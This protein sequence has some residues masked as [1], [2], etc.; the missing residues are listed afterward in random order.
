MSEALKTA[1]ASAPVNKI[2]L[3][4]FEFHHQGFTDDQ[5]IVR[6]WRFVSTLTSTEAIEATLEATAPVDAGKVV[7]F[8]P[9]PISA[10]HPERNDQGYTDFPISLGD[11][12]MALEEELDKALLHP[13]ELKVY[14]R[15]YLQNLD[16]GEITGPENVPFEWTLEGISNKDGQMNATATLVDVVNRPFPYLLYTP[17]FAPG[18]VR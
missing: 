2:V 9:A 15:L 6:P 10:K 7:R 11:V 12:T 5:G 1:Y 3:D 17:D 18:L 8:E 4:T 14:R 16:T 13:G